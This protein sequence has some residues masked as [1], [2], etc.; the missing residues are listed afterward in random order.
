MTHAYFVDY[1][2]QGI[3]PDPAM[4]PNKPMVPTA[5]TALNHHAPPSGRR[6]IGQPFG[7]FLSA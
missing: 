4:P 6:H 1:R 5:T 3:S 7:S 2:R